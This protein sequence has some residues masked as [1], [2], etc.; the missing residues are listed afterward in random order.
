MGKDRKLDVKQH[1]VLG[2]IIPGLTESAVLNDKEVLRLVDY[3][4]TMRHVSATAMNAT[5]SRSHCVFTFKTTVSE[6]EGDTKMSQTHLVD[7]ALANAPAP[8]LSR[9]AKSEDDLLNE[10]QTRI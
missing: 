4:Q 2:T 7:L 8:A 1:P 5:S 6:S 10:L 3:G 9:E